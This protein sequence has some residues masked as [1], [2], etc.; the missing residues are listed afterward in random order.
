MKKILYRM[1]VWGLAL[2]LSPIFFT[3]CGDDD[4][5]KFVPPKIEVSNDEIDTYLQ[6]NMLDKYN[7]AV[8][9][10]WE[11]R[12]IDDDY[13][14]T[15]VKRDVV[16]PV[17]KLVEYLWI[18]PYRSLGD[19]G[20]AFMDKLFPPELVYIGSYIFKE[21]GTR[22]LGYAEG[23]AR[24]T[25]LNLNSYDLTNKTWLTDPG[26]GILATVHHEFTHLVHQNFGMPVGFNTI[27]EK[28][29]GEG[30]SNNVSLADAIKL[31][32]VR[33]YGTAN[34]YED[35]CEIV[36]HFLTMPKASFE[37]LFINQQS[38]DGI[39]NPDQ[40]AHIQELNTGRKLIAKKVS[41]VADFYKNKFNID[42]YKLRDIM[43]ERINYVV[44][45]NKI[46]E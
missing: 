25:L 15:P 27:S 42:L 43:E 5:T 21:D 12:F 38:T 17:T 8:R 4:N 37:A 32:M 19:G 28:Y 18:D 11:D 26:G 22:L 10:K 23:G 16:I 29:N 2:L 30:W 33:N 1:T 39:T 24:I 3:S 9:W 36:S 45:N 46:P 13:T 7:T 6:N 40:I 20:K 34:E 44:T 14:A 35:F 41:V 31:G